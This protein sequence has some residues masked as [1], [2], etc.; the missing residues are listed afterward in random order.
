[1]VQKP[2]FSEVFNQAYSR[3]KH[4][5]QGHPSLKRRD[6][7]DLVQYYL[8]RMTGRY[9]KVSLSPIEKAYNLF[10]PGYRQDWKYQDIVQQFVGFWFSTQFHANIMFTVKKFVIRTS[11]ANLIQFLEADDELDKAFDRF[12]T[13]E[14][15]TD[16]QQEERN[17][18]ARNLIREF[19]KQC[20]FNDLDQA[21]LFAIETNEPLTMVFARYHLEDSYGYRREKELRY[22]LALFTAWYCKNVYPLF[23]DKTILKTLNRFSAMNKKYLRVGQILTLDSTN[24]LLLAARQHS[25]NMLVRL[26]KAELAQKSEGKTCVAYSLQEINQRTGMG[27][28][29][30]RE[31]SFI[32]RSSKSI[33]GKQKDHYVSYVNEYGYAYDHST[34]SGRW[35]IE[36]EWRSEKAG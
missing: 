4:S 30:C 28:R 36:P 10:D 2:A 15:M 12:S 16:S 8:D 32:G 5:L 31:G 35:L 23:S 18:Q 7:G 1:M 22:R 24:E 20:L 19:A 3:I 14:Y 29:P 34:G 21:I 9:K 13:K 26:F 17:T 6:C 25:W 27:F 11:K 33:N